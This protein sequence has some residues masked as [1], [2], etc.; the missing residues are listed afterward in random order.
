MQREEK[1]GRMLFSEVWTVLPDHM[2]SADPRQKLQMVNRNFGK[3]AMSA[4][5]RKRTA[6]C[7]H[8]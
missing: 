4:M 6:D 5:L 1:A 8:R 3:E 2:Q 7:Y